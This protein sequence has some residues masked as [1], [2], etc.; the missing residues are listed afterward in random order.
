VKVDISTIV[1][2]MCATSIDPRKVGRSKEIVEIFPV[3]LERITKDASYLRSALGIR[4]EGF[5]F[6]ATLLNSEIILDLKCLSKIEWS[7]I[8]C[9]RKSDTNVVAYLR[10]SV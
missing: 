10:L 7:I 8:F 6:I 4:D 2:A 5:R 3:F 1:D 9:L